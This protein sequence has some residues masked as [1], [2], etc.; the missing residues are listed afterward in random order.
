MGEFADLAIQEGML[1]ELMDP[2]AAAEDAM[3]QEWL[4]KDRTKRE[5]DGRREKK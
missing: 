1:R 2:D 4:E 3:E 5:K